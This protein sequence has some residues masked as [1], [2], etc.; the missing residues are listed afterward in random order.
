MRRGAQGSIPGSFMAG[1]VMAGD[2][3]T[4]IARGRVES[5]YPIVCRIAAAPWL[6]FQHCYRD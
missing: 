1:D 4:F 3:V 2:E 6:A 5:S